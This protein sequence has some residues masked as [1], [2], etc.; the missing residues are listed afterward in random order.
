MF[1]L[2]LGEYHSVLEDA[3]HQAR[4]GREICGLLIH[5]GYHL[6]LIPIRN[7]AA[8]TGAFQLSRLEV[9]RAVAASETL[10]QEVVGTYHSHL[11]STATP[12]TSDIA[13]AVDD[14]LMFIFDC[15]GR[16]GRLWRIRDGKA[17]PLRISYL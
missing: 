5:T 9:R 12:G 17:R 10:R 13:N 3:C 11:L 7:V 1:R 4:T 16:K 15:F 6:K 8:R 2:E 14:S